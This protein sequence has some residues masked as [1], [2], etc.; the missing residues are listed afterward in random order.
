MIKVYVDSC[1][2][3]QTRNVMK[4]KAAGELQS[5]RPECPWEIIATDVMGLLPGTSKRNQFIITATDLFTK[6]VCGKAIAVQNAETV[7]RFLVFEVFL[8]YGVPHKILSDQGTPFCNLLTKAIFKL[9]NV[10]KLTTSGYHPQ[11]NGQRGRFNGTLASMLSKYVDGNQRD[12]DNALPYL[13]FAYNTSQHATIGFTPYKMLYARE[14]RLT[15]IC[16]LSWN[17]LLRI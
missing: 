10:K 5:F 17:R 15:S 13:L 6:W 1:V 3:C 12:W 11:T 2:E 7:A 14:F 16:P 9:F 8:R 4:Q